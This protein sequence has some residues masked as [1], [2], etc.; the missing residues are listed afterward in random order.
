MKRRFRV[1]IEGESYE[2][3]IE[4]LEEMEEMEKTEVKDS[5][6]PNEKPPASAVAPQ[7]PPK[8]SPAIRP[9][10]VRAG[11]EVVT[12]PMPGTIVSL[13]VRVGD[14]VKAGD[15]LLVLESMKIQNEIPSPTDGKIKEILVPEGNYVKRRQPLIVIGS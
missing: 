13:N 4:E 14:S 10:T 7:F 8:A 9:P 11:E 6:S 15:I 2:V 3:E 12:S 5:N 1:T